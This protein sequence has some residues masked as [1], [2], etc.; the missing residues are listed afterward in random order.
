MRKWI[1]VFLTMCLMFPSVSVAQSLR[2]LTVEDGLASSAVTC[3]HQS[4]DGLLWF[5]TLDGMNFYYGQQ[6]HRTSMIPLGALEGHI[7]EEIVE[8]A[9]DYM[10][11]QTSYGLHQLE[12]LTRKTNSFYQFTGVYRIRLIGKNQ[13]MVQDTDARFHIY[14]AEEKRFVPVDYTPMEGE[15]LKSFG[16]T[17]DF[18]WVAGNKGIYR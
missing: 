2:Q 4:R 6:V 17:E 12:R 9:D 11:I 15:S 13:V 8:T 1:I 10:W 14:Q 5:G 18:C 7:I 3:V 16:G